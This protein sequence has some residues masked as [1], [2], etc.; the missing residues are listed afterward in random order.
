MPAS[1]V[2]NFLPLPSLK[3]VCC[4]KN[5]IVKLLGLPPGR[6]HYCH[7]VIYPLGGY[8]QTLKII[9]VACV[10]F[11]CLQFFVDIQ[12]VLLCSSIL[13]AAYLMPATVPD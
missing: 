8:C 12:V 4:E 5:P 9:A 6:W 11:E 10:A 1:A 7:I 13:V 2:L 3:V